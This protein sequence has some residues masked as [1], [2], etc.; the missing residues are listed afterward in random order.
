MA[1]KSFKEKMEGL[2]HDNMVEECFEAVKQLRLLKKELEG[3]EKEVLEGGKRWS[4]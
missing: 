1:T 4:G 2:S 3:K